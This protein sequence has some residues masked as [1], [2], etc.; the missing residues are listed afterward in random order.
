MPFDGALEAPVVVIGGGQAGLSASYYLKQN[1]IKH[2]ILETHRAGHAWRSER[3]DSFCLVTPNEQCRLPDFPYDGGDPEG[4][5]V[6]SEIVDFMD[7]FV[8][9]TKPPILEGVTVLSVAREGAGFYLR[10]TNGDWRCQSVICAIGACHLPIIPSLSQHVPH[11]IRQFHSSSYRNP[12][13]LPPGEVLVVGTGQSG[14]QLAEE[15]MMAGRTVHLAVG[16]APRSP[17][18]YRGKDAVTWLEEMGY[19]RMSIADHPD[20]QRAIHSSNHYLSGR[21]GGHEIDLRELA[22]KGLHLYGRLDRADARGLYFRPNLTAQLDAADASYNGICR[23]IDA[24]IEQEGIAAPPGEHY[25]ARWAPA[26]EPLAIDLDHTAIASI[27]WCTGFRP[28]FRMLRFAHIAPHELPSTQ[29]G[30]SALPGLYFLGLPWMHTWG[31]A[32]FAG[33]ADDARFVVEHLLTHCL[34]DPLSI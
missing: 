8:D 34:L 33:V 16:D 5:M 25:T 11:S 27:L 24:Y 6:Q 21:D 1:G 14:C 28:D 19:Y 9:Q 20:P 4:F 2:V 18:R 31:S 17:R 7:R 29:R 26:T 22:Q 15:L 23:R 12:D 30:A 3:W 10:T 13:S 32:R